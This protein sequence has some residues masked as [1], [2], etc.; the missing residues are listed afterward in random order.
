MS[1]RF[2]EPSDVDAMWAIFHE[3]AAGGDTIPTDGSASR[4][5]LARDWFDDTGRAWVAMD[6]ETVVGMY[7]LGA[8]QP[9][10]GAH[11]GTATFLVAAAHRRKGVGGR[12]VAHCLDEARAAGYAGIQFNF[13]V[14]TNASA[15]ALYRRFGFSIVGTLPG[16][17]EHRHLGRVDAHVLYRKLA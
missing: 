2:A 6:E 15:L 8:N 4:D 16:A 11:V 13:V 10:R 17:F 3:A 9:D 5:A 7:R 1:I 12:L 14:G